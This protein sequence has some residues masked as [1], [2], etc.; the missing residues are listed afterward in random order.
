MN[1][2]DRKK[3]LLATI[4]KYWDTGY[5][6]VMGRVYGA[7]VFVITFSTLLKVNGVDVGLF[8]MFLCFLGISVFIFVCGVIYIKLDLLKLE[9]ESFF[10]ENPPLCRIEKGIE[11][12][13]ARLK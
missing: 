7:V 8:E 6:K 12:L 4:V 5:S 1:K 13:E 11:R 2:F 10:E 9:T 3:R